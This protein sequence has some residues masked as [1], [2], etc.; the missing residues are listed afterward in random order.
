[1]TTQS[2]T[3]RRFRD[4]IEAY[5]AHAAQWPQDERDAALAFMA[6]H[7][8]EAQAW[9]EAAGELDAW[10]DEGRDGAAQ[11]PERLHYQTVARM[12]AA[13]DVTGDAGE[14]GPRAR[15]RLPLM[16]AAGAGLVACLAGGVLGVNIGLKGVDDMRAQAVLEQAQMIDAENG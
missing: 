8:E 16:W 13:N 6:A 7:G 12:I 3:A 9:L 11:V 10:L 15:L 1:M 4:M 5:G 14:V 2:M